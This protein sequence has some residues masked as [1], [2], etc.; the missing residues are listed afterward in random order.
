LRH[1]FV[2]IACFFA[3]V[4][5]AGAACSNDSLD[6]RGDW[7]RVSFQVEVVDTNESRAQGLMF[8]DELAAFS[9]ML[10]VYDRPQR[11]AFWMKNT[12][13]ALDMIFIDDSGVV[14]HVHD[15]AVPGD[16]TPIPGGDDI[17]AVLEING[18]LAGQLQ[19]AEGSQIR[20][21]AFAASGPAWPC[22]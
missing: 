3:L 18:G 10:F 16:L 2:S 15:S 14:Q 13:I 21:P 1:F 20:H 19:L 9:G 7:G 11:V 12:L 4:Q 5:H 6:V 17:F 8:R 22:E